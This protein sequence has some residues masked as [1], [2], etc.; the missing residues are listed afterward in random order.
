MHTAW[1]IKR[2][3]AR[4]DYGHLP[5]SAIG[6]WA[7]SQANASMQHKN[8][9]LLPISA[10]RTGIDQKAKMMER[11]KKALTSR[12]NFT[13]EEIAH[14][15][16]Q[17]SEHL[18]D[19][20]LLMNFEYFDVPSSD[21]MLQF[22]F[23]VWDR[24]IAEVMDY[25]HNYGKDL[26]GIGRPVPED[27]IWYH[28]TYFEGMAI[29]EH[30]KASSIV[31]FIAA[32]EDILK[33]V[34]FG[35]GNVPERRYGLM[36]YINTLTVFDDGPVSPVEEL[37]R[38]KDLAR[39]NYIH[40]SLSSAPAYK[41][42]L[43]AQDLVWMHGVSMY[44]DEVSKYQ[45]TG[46]ILAGIALLRNRGYMKYDYLL[47]TASMRRVIETQNWPYDPHHPMII[48]NSV[49]AAISQARETLQNVNLRLGDRTFVD[50]VNIEPTLIE[51]WGVTSVRITLRKYG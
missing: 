43:G 31:E 42:L 25:L 2:H 19:P 15:L 38:A 12:S 11:V 22:Y 30:I 47:W 23:A 40:E 48:F 50:I 6:E 16:N 24:R 51:P 3:P 36:R 44:L 21:F 33:V 45:M 29:N 28:M 20:G 5:N 7:L 32:H 26:R 17:V 8:K 13:A 39:I 49:D 34:S 35:G 18:E 10:T 9:D 41:E 37:F 27:D 1:D 14:R 46:A 4:G